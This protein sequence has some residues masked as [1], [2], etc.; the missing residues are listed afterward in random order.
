[1]ERQVLPHHQ[2]PVGATHAGATAELSFRA[3]ARGRAPQ[4]FADFDPQQRREAVVAAG[5]RPFRADQVARHYF[6]RFEADPAQ[7]T[8]LAPADR[9][10]ARDLLP[11]LIT[12]VVTQVA[13]KGWTRKTLWRLF[14]GAQ[15][16]SVLMRYPKRVTLCV[17]SQVGCGMGC[18]FCATGQLGL[19]R[20]LSAA[21][22]LEQV[23]LAARAAQD[24]ELGSPARLSNLVFMGMGEPLANYKSLLHTIRTLTAEV[25][26]GFGISARNLVVSTVG[27]VP[28]IRKLTQEGLPVTLAVSLHAPDD[29]LRNELIPMNR[30]YQVDELLDT[31]YAYFQATG[32]RVSIEYAL[33]RDMNDHP[34]RAQL[35][36][37]K[38]NERGKTW[39]HVNPIPLNPTP[40]SIWD[41]SLPRVMDEF[42]EIL[43]QAGISTT[44][45]DTR[46]SDIDGACGQLAAKAKQSPAA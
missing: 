20:N 32:R 22:I 36:A 10:R 12:P 24:G 23:R 31:A 28:G 33:I 38:L 6:G 43:R 44:L 40:G 35:L 41:A 25:P 16:E 27:L 11:E 37:D 45:R 42:M 34:W 18:P 3:H 13:D 17:S 2:P 29:E 30:R 26:Q 7:M 21:E 1:M 19:T 15:V 46:G 9:E 14:D 39:A 4:H 5:M 8:D